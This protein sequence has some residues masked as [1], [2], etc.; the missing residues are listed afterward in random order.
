MRKRYPVIV[1]TMLLLLAG[2]EL[3]VGAIT[4]FTNAN[5]TEREA[6]ALEDTATIWIGS[7]GGVVRWDLNSGLYTKYT[8][9]EGLP[10]NL[11]MAIAVEDG[12]AVWFGTNFGICRYDGSSWIT[13][14]TSDGLADNYTESLAF[15][16]NGTLWAGTG[17]GVSSFDGSTWTTYS[18][19]V[20]APAGLVRDIAISDA[21]AV[22][23]GYWFATF[24]QGLF[25]FDGASTWTNYTPANT[26]NDV[27]SD[28]LNAVEADAAGNIWFA[29]WPPAQGGVTM[30]DGTN[31]NHYYSSDGLVSNNILDIHFDQDGY[32]W[33]GAVLGVSR[34]D[35]GSGW[36]TYSE[37]DGL[38][39]DWVHAITS[40]NDG[41]TYLGTIKGLSAKDGSSY[42]AYMTND[43]FSGGDFLDIA[44]DLSGKVWFATYFGG[45]WSFDGTGWQ[46]YT[47]E[48]G[49]AGDWV[50]SIGIDLDN[51][52]WF[53]ANT[54][55]NLGVTHYDENTNPWTIYNTGDGLVHNRV[56]A[57]T[58]DGAGNKWFGTPGGAS[59]FDGSNWTSYTTANGLVNNTIRAVAADEQDNIWFATGGG[60]SFYDVSSDTWTNYTTGDGLPSDN[61]SDIGVDPVGNVWISTLGYGAA[62]FDGSTW[63]TYTYLDGLAGDYVRNLAID[64]FGNVWFTTYY[65]GVSK[66]NGSHWTTYSW[67]ADGLGSKDYR[68]IASDKYGNIWLGGFGDATITLIGS[69]P[70]GELQDIITYIENMSPSHFDKKAH[71]KALVNQLKSLLKQLD[72]INP[73]AAVARLSNLI[74]K[75][76]KWITDPVD[77][78]KVL[79]VLNGLIDYYEAQDAPGK[80]KGKGAKLAGTETGALSL[81]RAFALAQ[82]SPNPFN[83]ATTITYSIP[84]GTQ[85]LVTLKIFDLR[86]RVIRTLVNA[87]LPSGSYK[88]LWDGTKD[89]GW[90]AASGVYF[91]RLQAGEFTQT[92]KM[93]LLK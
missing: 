77:Q 57:I 87:E 93:V 62:V 44:V 38:P 61:V 37:N 84:E 71:Q 63:T 65:Y 21:S 80:G 35:G 27:P 2:Y 59:K 52:K 9:E 90:V 7:R 66:F 86:G 92:R 76:E 69:L 64:I 58:I 72:G 33:F 67:Y 60:V 26:G 20:G 50:R 23:D 29:T 32:G 25:H 3:A 19:G 54:F 89:S 53:G 6:I 73:N 51:S 75:A 91:Y 13:Y 43:L 70:S 45:V 28:R 78:L 82:N 1:A 24:S 14:T 46:N 41:K 49:L 55:S 79:T 88:V 42:T 18:S 36:T 17:Q 74:D 4:N 47:E 8:T 15:D 56:D 81:P 31:W 5:F 10:S 22:T 12:R 11:V 16:S 68:V 83:P 30:Y 48:D 39:A 34:F 85:G 40:G